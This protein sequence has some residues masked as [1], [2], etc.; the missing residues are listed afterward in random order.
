VNQNRRRPPIWHLPSSSVAKVPKFRPQNT[1]GAEKHSAGPGKSRAEFLPDLS[2]RGRIF[3][4]LSFS[5][6][7]LDFLAK[8]ILIIWFTEFF[9]AMSGRESLKK[10]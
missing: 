5:R 4:G 6:I 2:K 10:Q 1:K 7:H 9:L 8:T 3:M